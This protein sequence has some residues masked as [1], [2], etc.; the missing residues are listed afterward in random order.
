[1][2]KYGEYKKFIPWLK[3]RQKRKP[4]QPGETVTTLR[5]DFKKSTGIDIPPKTAMAYFQDTFGSGALPSKFPEVK[6]LTK[7][8]I[9]K[10]L[11]EGKT[12]DIIKNEWAKENNVVEK[13]SK[14]RT[15]GTKNKFDSIAQNTIYNVINKNSDLKKLE[16]TIKAN[17][18]STLNSKRYKKYIKDNVSKYLKADGS[19]KPGF[20]EDLY[21][22][23]VEYFKKTYPGSVQT[24]SNLKG[25]QKRIPGGTEFIKLKE[26]AGASAGSY[27]N[28]RAII[29]EAAEDK[30]PTAIGKKAKKSG[31]ERLKARNVKAAESLGMT[32]SQYESLI[33]KNL[34]YPLGKLF[35]SL[36]RTPYAAS[37]EHIYP[38]QQAIATNMV[39]ELKAGSKAIVPSTKKLNLLVKGPQLDAKATSQ[40]RLAYE[41]SDPKIK[42]KYLDTANKL[43]ADFKKKFP[44]S[45][46]KYELTARN[47]IVNVNPP[48]PGMLKA[49]LTKK[50]T[51]YIDS[52]VKTPGF[53][54]SSEFKNLPSEASQLILSRK[55]PDFDFNLNN[56]I[57]KVKSVPGGCRA[58]VTRAL[59]GPLDTC[60]AIIKADPERAAVKL[61]NS[62][63]ATKGPLKDLKKDSQ[64]LIRLYRGEEPARKTELYKATKGSPSMYEE[65][66]KGRFFFDNPADA[67]YYAQRQ[68]SLTGNVKSVDVP[69]NM[70]KIG[71]K[72]AIR[73]RGPNYGSEVI[74][75]KK[76]VGQEKINI[77]QTAM[78]RAGAIVDKIKSGIKYNKDAGTFVNTT[79]NA[80][81]TNFNAKTYA[82]D[83]PIEVKAGTEDAL[84]P[85]KGNLLKTVGKSLAYVGAPLPT[86]LI[87]S[88]FVGKQISEDRPAAEIAKDP[89]NWLGLATMS[90]LSN[91]SGVSKPGKMNA[92]L[93]L[94]MSPGLIRGVSRFA[95]IPGLAISTAL[96]AYDQYNK[97]KNEEGLIYNLFNKKTETIA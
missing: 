91:I 46:P 66:L 72:M 4:F 2:A 88:Y 29:R 69:E 56:F 30:L 94:G 52:L 27:E 21:T 50:V 71:S 26:G 62:I 83:N 6:L 80:P 76:F 41:A 77:P 68:G 31:F 51:E 65:S 35:P 37:A 28:A 73:R 12:K 3:S 74:L 34:T 43:I 47:N 64:K 25:G 13:I 1:M 39:G 87:D 82:Q 40:L 36:F 89:L 10:K 97:Y 14:G 20:R 7:E 85:I 9:E 84:K 42:Q 19:Y 33:N 48:G 23:A 5:A 59:G 53:L 11:K 63:N 22:D 24:Y 17:R 58:V 96:T 93:R 18:N 92:A 75:P 67:R 15:L 86:A 90:T 79:T 81:D 45:Y 78:A 38:L 57:K 61:N 70:A 60:E 32:G 55:K 44:G 8:Y 16:N 54:E 95:G 49:P